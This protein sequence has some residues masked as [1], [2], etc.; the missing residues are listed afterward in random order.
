MNRSRAKAPKQILALSR[1][2]SGRRKAWRRSDLAPLAVALAPHLLRM[3][4]DEF[5]MVVMGCRVFAQS[6]RQTLLITK[7]A[8]IHRAS[9]A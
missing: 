2:S 6:V 7:A 5:D 1:S 4:Q 3:T 8:M 9:A